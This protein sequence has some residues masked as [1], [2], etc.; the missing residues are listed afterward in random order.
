MAEAIA[1]AAA[2]VIGLTDHNTHLSGTEGAAI[3]SSSKAHSSF[4]ILQ[5]EN[6]ASLNPLLLAIFIIF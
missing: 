5:G 3:G 4:Y 2:A 1:S 6:R